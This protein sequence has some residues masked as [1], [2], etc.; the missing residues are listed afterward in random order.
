MAVREDLATVCGDQNRFRY[1]ASGST[2]FVEPGTYWFGA[3]AP[4]VNVARALDLPVKLVGN[5]GICGEKLEG[6]NA[7][8]RVIAAALRKRVAHRV[9]GPGQPIQF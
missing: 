9:D 2:T 4:L 5:L 1:V 7:T 6:L 3:A 8:L